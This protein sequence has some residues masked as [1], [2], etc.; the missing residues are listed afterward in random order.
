MDFVVEFCSQLA[1]VCIL[2]AIAVLALAC[3]AFLT[4]STI[5]LIGSF[6][7]KK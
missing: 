1:C 6:W 2:L 3:A 4:I 7:R 5:Q